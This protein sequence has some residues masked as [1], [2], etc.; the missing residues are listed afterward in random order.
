LLVD[1]NI[2]LSFQRLGFSREDA[3][4]GSGQ[5]LDS[6]LQRFPS[7]K[8]LDIDLDQCSEPLSS[9][10]YLAGGTT[11]PTSNDG[12][13]PHHERQQADRSNNITCLSVQLST[14]GRGSDLWKTSRSAPALI[15]GLTQ[16][17]NLPNLEQLHVTFRYDLDYYD[18][19]E[20]DE[21][22][23]WFAQFDSLQ[24]AAEKWPSLQLV[25]VCVRIGFDKDTQYLGT[26]VYG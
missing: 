24:A 20:E 6:Y 13:L 3:T 2:N 12:E 1:S 18:E 16:I 26:L 25:K 7:A 17:L 9:L 22:Q 15:S 14:M 4:P 21:N 23:R 10:E 11:Y 8:R 19:H 5:S